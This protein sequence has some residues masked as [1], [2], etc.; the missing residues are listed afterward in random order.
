MAKRPGSENEIVE[1]RE[2]LASVQ[3]VTKGRGGKNNWPQMQEPE[4]PGT[5]ARYLRHALASLNLP[6]ID[7]SDI[8]QCEQRA[9]EYFNQ[10]IAD[11]IKPNLVGLCNWLGIS[12]DTLHAWRNG[13]TRSDTHSDFFKKCELIMEQISVGYLLDGK[14]NPAAGIFILKNHH[15]YRDVT[16]LTIE[17]RQGITDATAEDVARKYD[18]LPD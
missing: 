9:N 3:T 11:D 14:V 17:P 10:C 16:D 5:N 13:I 1:D 12:R 8:N 2:Q 4:E 15:A 6:P 18:E 7:I